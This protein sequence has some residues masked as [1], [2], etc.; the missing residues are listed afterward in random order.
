LARD[1]EPDD[2][3]PRPLRIAHVNDIAFVGSTLARAMRELGED[4]VVVE[5]F[6]L[7]TNLRYPWKAA[8]LPFR[9]AGLLGAAATVRRGHFD[10]VHVHYARLGMVGPLTGRP[11]AIHVHGTDIRGVR[12]RSFWGRETAP[13]LRRAGLVYYATPD[14]E[15]WVRPFR[16][17]AIL[18]PNPIETDRFRPL[19]A[20]DPARPTRRD[21]LV[22]VR[23]APIKGLT[24]ILEVLRMLAAERPATTIT[25]VAQGE[26]V[27]AA[28]AVAGPNATIV[29]PA[30]RDEL[31]ELM[32]GHRLALGQF[33]V[34]A[35]G[36]YEIEAL[37][38]GVPVVMRFDQGSAYTTQPPVANAADAGQAVA[39]ICELL[40]DERALDDL[41]ARGPAWVDGNHAAL[42]VAARVIADYRRF[43]LAPG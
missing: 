39:R 15:Q 34:G 6:R 36:N 8:A 33:L 41:A 25:I 18:L 2:H 12:P 21:L 20:D 26:G 16:D 23:L 4:A 11:Y 43:G 7:R 37:S 14:L 28:R 32:R 35:M 10:V 9:A 31:A 30:S 19:A 22:G 40:D 3:R 17:D 42:T 24:T 13:L 1:L 5:P 38:T 27:E 29:A